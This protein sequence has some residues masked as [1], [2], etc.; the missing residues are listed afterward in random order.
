MKKK[1]LALVLVLVLSL[2]T[3]LV[4]TGCGG[5]YNYDLSKYVEVGEYTGLE[6]DKIDVEVTDKEIRDEINSRLE[7]A[8]TDKQSTSGTVKDGDTVNIDYAGKVAGKAFDG[9]TAENQ[10]LVIGSK[11]MIEGFEDGLIGEAVGST[12][13]LNLTFPD[14]YTNSPEMAGKDVVFEVTINSKTVKDIPE[15]NLE[16]IKAN[17]EYTTIK[18]YEASVKQDLYDAEY[19]DALYEVKNGLWE[20]IVA[21]STVKDY[22][23]KELKMKT[24]DLNTQYLDMAKSYN[25]EWE[26]FLKQS[27]M[28]QEDWDAQVDE[29][30][31]TVV[32]Q[33]MI[34]YA[35][36]DKEG[37]ELSDNEY[38]KYLEDMLKQSGYDEETFK[39]AYGQSLEEYAESKDWRTGLMLDKVLDVVLEKG[40]EK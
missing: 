13:K 39:T 17:S 20:K 4:L 12:V 38:D 36:A 25:M 23:E 32:G 28:T 27:G 21:A 24:K 2:M 22:P 37:I 6:Y 33:E 1:N 11:K 8:A 29:Y 18:D 10:T 35:I 40:V 14:P 34:M 26:D 31:K 16:F 30:A 5:K 3:T 15:Y 7:K 9:G 19:Q